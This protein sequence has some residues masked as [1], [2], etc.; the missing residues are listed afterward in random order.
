MK[1]VEQTPMTHHED[2]RRLSGVQLALLGVE[3][4]NRYD[5]LLRCVTCGETWT[6]P[7]DREG[8]LMPGY[9]ICPQ[10]CNQ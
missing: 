10:R 4:M 9:W 2:P 7:L 1:I 5:L 8:K 3:L 6:A